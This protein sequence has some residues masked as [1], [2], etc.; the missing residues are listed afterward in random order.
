MLPLSSPP[1][2]SAADRL[3]RFCDEDNYQEAFKRPFLLKGDTYATDGNIIVRFLGEVDGVGQ[4]PEGSIIDPTSA[5]LFG[6]L[7]SQ[8]EYI[9]WAAVQ[10]EDRDSKYECHA[11]G[12]IG[13]ESFRCDM[14]DGEGFHEC[15]CGSEHKC[16]ECH[17]VGRVPRPDGGRCDICGGKTLQPAR[18][19]GYLF[20]GY[21][22][23]II[24]KFLDDV[25]YGTVPHRDA[26]YFTHAAGDGLVMRFRE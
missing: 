22:H 21:Y 16:G 4:R 23:T 13:F 5:G 12:G 7:P 2:L 14:C 6:G 19:A 18:V 9:E 1:V 25:N 20:Q 8:H 10:T 15:R 11:C 24:G 17:G 26:V 3:K